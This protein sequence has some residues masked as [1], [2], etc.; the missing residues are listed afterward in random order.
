MYTMIAKVFGMKSMSVRFKMNLTVCLIFIIVAAMVLS[1]S[2][3]NS[4][5]ENLAAGISRVQEMNTFYFDSLN[6]MMLTGTMSERSILRDKI[7]RHDGVLEVRVNRGEPVN[8]QFGPGFAE[9]RPVDALDHRALQG[10]Q[11]IKV[12]EHEGHRAI[13]VIMPYKATENTRGVNCLNCHTVPSGSV[14][15]AIR[16]SYS[17]AEAD[18]LAM[19]DWWKQFYVVIGL[20]IAG[21]FTV[22]VLVNRIVAQPIRNVVERIKD[23][24][25]GEGDLTTKLDDSSNDE[26][27]ELAYWFNTF[28]SKL[29]IMITDINGYASALT[30]NA[31]HMS[32]VTNRT[33]TGIKQQQSETDQVAIAMNQMSETV[34]KVARNASSAASA[35]NEA[36]NEASKGK[37]VVKE[38]IEAIDSLAAEV[39]KAGTVIQK[40]EEDSNGIGVVLDVIRGIA[41]QTNLLALNAAIE[42]ARA[43]E[44]GR[45]FAVVADEVRTLAQRTQQSTQ[46]I[47]AIIEHLQSGAKN[48]VKVMVEGK[49]QANISV[50]QAAKAGSSLDT[51]TQVV[52]TITDMNTR[53]ASAAEEHSTVAEEINDNVA[54]ISKA[55]NHTAE[56]ATEVAQS[57][58]QLTKLADDLQSLLGHFKV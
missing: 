7:L 26:L 27:G 11:I 46:E 49:N 24:A 29:R 35:A 25:E 5:H 36:D 31:E 15:G 18:T 45:G 21:L 55:A 30:T 57:S 54:N 4:R 58:K 10:E 8:T 39:E 43:G 42:A 52:T 20:F 51:I 9:E 44:Q 48:A 40:L 47:R 41:E 23:I 16:I 33:S 34:Q 28:V 14:N 17:L 22:S 53:I 6:I 19:A 2:Y 32:A 3:K 37:I 1:L 12:S 38:T 13:T 56:D 50:E